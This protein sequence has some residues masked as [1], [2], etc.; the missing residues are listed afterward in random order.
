M[1]KSA[2]TAVAGLRMLGHWEYLFCL[3]SNDGQ[4][5]GKD[6]LASWRGAKSWRR[7]KKVGRRIGTDSDAEVPPPI[8]LMVT[9]GSWQLQ[10]LPTRRCRWIFGVRLSRAMSSAR[11]ST[12]GHPGFGGSTCLHT[13]S[14]FS[15]VEIGAG[16]PNT[17]LAMKKKRLKHRLFRGSWS[18]PGVPWP[19]ETPIFLVVSAVGFLGIS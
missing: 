5:P 1:R 8:D 7:L 12:A 6:V 16:G 13:R 9:G 19:T 17:A 11:T 18:L 4:S 3:C 15:G 10:Q 14:H 2:W